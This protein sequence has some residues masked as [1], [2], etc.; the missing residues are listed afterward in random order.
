ME[1][2]FLKKENSLYNIKI[3]NLESKFLLSVFFP[4]LVGELYLGVISYIKFRRYETHLIFQ[5]KYG[6]FCQ[7]LLMDVSS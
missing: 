2:V 3:C 5:N 7:L 1:Y 6:I 4:F